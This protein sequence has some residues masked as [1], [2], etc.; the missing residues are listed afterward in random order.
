M[1][2]EQQLNLKSYMPLREEDVGCV[3][4]SQCVTVMCGFVCVCV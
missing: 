4:V 1:I 3:I 2:F